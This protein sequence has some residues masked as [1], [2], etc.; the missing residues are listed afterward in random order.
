MSVYDSQLLSKI[1]AKKKKEKKTKTKNETPVGENLHRSKN[2]TLV[3][4]HGST[5]TDTHTDTHTDRQTTPVFRTPTI[6]IH[7]VNE[8]D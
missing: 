8:N 1:A 4:A 2:K 5:Q 6:T 7:S 3:L